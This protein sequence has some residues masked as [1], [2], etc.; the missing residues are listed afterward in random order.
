MYY[1][2]VKNKVK[3]L[4]KNRVFEVVFGWMISEFSEGHFE[5]SGIVYPNTQ[6]NNSENPDPQQPS[7][8]DFRSF[9]KC[10]IFRIFPISNM[11]RM[12][13][14]N[15]Q[16]IWSPKYEHCLRRVKRSRYMQAAT[17]TSIS[18]KNSRRTCAELNIIRSVNHIRQKVCDL[19]RVKQRKN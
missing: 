1:Y 2:S 9:S 14:F 8:K 6:N 13:Q 5:K 12:V 11:T 18:P 3:I 7:C 19:R 15:F 4:L 16:R 10:N 17:F